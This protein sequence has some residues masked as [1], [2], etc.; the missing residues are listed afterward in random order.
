[1]RGVIREGDKLSSGGAV[2]SGAS[3]MQFLGQAVACKGDK[4]FCPL[5][6]HGENEI[7]EGDEGSQYQGRP[8][9]LDGHRCYC[10]CTLLTSL[11]QAGRV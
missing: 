10:G 7:A 1:M 8:I 4:V 2:H 9:A 3:G 5:P 11:P 6:G